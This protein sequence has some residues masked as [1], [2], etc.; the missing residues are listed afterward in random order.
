MSIDNIDYYTKYLK[1]KNKYLTLKN[2]LGGSSK[3]ET[4]SVMS[5]IEFYKIAYSK[6]M[7]MTGSSHCSQI[8]GTKSSVDKFDKMN[9][10][11]VI[12]NPKASE[13]LKAAAE[14][15]KNEA[16]TFGQ[17]KSNLQK[18]NPA[19]LTCKK[20]SSPSSRSRSRSRSS[21]S[22]SGSWMPSA[23]TLVDS[24]TLGGFT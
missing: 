10:T 17:L 9:I 19:T 13:Q 18:E 12:S 14:K 5:A 4:D 3:T 1:Y 16:S 20:T 23:S 6:L 7:T 2:R 15:Y 22:S 11:D 24:F 8:P 21:S